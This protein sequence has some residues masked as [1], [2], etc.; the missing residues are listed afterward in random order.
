MEFK[1][2]IGDWLSLIVLS[3]LGFLLV[4]CSALLPALVHKV[5]PEVSEVRIKIATGEDA[6]KD[7]VLSLNATYGKPTIEVSA[8]RL[9]TGEFVVMKK[10]YF[11]IDDNTFVVVSVVN[12]KTLMIDTIHG[13]ERERTNNLTEYD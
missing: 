9:E 3:L 10:L 1:T 11:Y 4:G 13:K 12:D 8:F 5:P 7:V 2:T 6:L